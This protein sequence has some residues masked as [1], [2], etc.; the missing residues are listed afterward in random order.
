MSQ[1]L[2]AQQGDRLSH[3]H[4]AEAR[5]MGKPFGSST[6]G[7]TSYLPFECHARIYII[8]LDGVYIET[9]YSL[10]NRFPRHDDSS[11]TTMV[12]CCN[13]YEAGVLWSRCTN[14]SVATFS[15]IVVLLTAVMIPIGARKTPATMIANANIHVGVCSGLVST[16][17]TGFRL[18][19]SS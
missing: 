9:I 1:F 6:I 5:N 17:T 10:A 2:V 18:N 19:M 8:S 7:S 11:D 13:Q 16:N 4:V 12:F 3:C 14:N 15:P